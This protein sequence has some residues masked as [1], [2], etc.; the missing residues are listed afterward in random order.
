M[1]KRTINIEEKREKSDENLKYH[2]IECFE[3]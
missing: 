2:A 1:F 3:K